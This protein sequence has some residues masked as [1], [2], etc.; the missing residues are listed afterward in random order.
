M[1]GSAI[2]WALVVV[3][4]AGCGEGSYRPEV[5]YAAGVPVETV[6][7]IELALVARCED[8]PFG[9]G[10]PLVEAAESVRLRRGEPAPPFLDLD[11]E[12]PR[13]LWGRARNERC[14]VVAEGCLPVDLEPGGGGVLSL[15]LEGAPPSGCLATEVCDAGLCLDESEATRCEE[16]DE[17]CS[18]GAREGVCRGGSCCTGCW[19]G[20][21]CRTGTESLSCGSSGLA[22]V[23]C[24][25][26][27]N[28]C[29]LGLCA[30]GPDV[31]T[32]ASGNDFLCATTDARRLLCWGA[33]GQ[34]ET[35]TGLTTELIVPRPTSVA[36]EDLG[37]EPTLE[38]SRASLGAAH[39]C[40]VLL[41]GEV[42]C[43]GDN[44][45]GQLAIAVENG[46]S[47]PRTV[48]LPHERAL[49]LG[50]AAHSCGIDAAGLLSCWGRNMSGELGISTMSETEIPTRIEGRRFLEVAVAESATCAV[51]EA[52][53]LWCWGS[54][55]FGRLG[56]GSADVGPFT[57]PRLV[58]DSASWS[59][60]RASRRG[61]CAR[62]DGDYHCWGF[63]RCGQLG[64]GDTTTRN[65]PTPLMFAG[66]VDALALGTEHGVLVDGDGV[67][68]TWGSNEYLQTLRPPP[69]PTM[70]GC[71][72][73]GAGPS[74]PTRVE[75]DNRWTSVA[76]G[77]YHT[78]AVDHEGE[79]HC[80]GRD[81]VG[82]LGQGMV[83][84]PSAELLRVC[85]PQE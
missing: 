19:D 59:D 73:D 51:D 14:E 63:N 81:H 57:S 12:L 22:C 26:P 50:N 16:E 3:W 28:A 60:L 27:L 77:S 40:G 85:M 20:A 84:T 31:S 6:A 17:R 32:L 83:G 49:A 39:G 62:R 37:C 13:G 52:S 69:F 82:Q 70:E 21:A 45:D 38:W 48:S 8:Q 74:S 4:H 55:Q 68:H 79:L 53:A 33:N 29:V 42:A 25:C 66:D 18:V 10:G 5:D 11:G 56:I 24:S 1:R 78:C 61:F 54:N 75:T 80:G 71:V 9:T 35:G 30:E 47:R 36:C 46:V 43:W 58:D 23:G 34:D 76:A 64:V 67:L 44:T 65:T 41:G 2:T 7:S 72:G 15:R